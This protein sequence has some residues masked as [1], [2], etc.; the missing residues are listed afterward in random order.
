MLSRIFFTGLFISFLGT[1]PLGTLNVLAARM[2]VDD[3][4]GPAIW[5]SLGA[6]IVEMVY[7]RL[8]L[9][10]M[11]WIRRQKKWLRILEGLTVCV[12]LLLAIGSF[13]AAA[14]PHRGGSVVIGFIPPAPVPRF[15][16]GMALS[17]INPLQIPFWF[18]WSTVLF[19][20]KILLPRNDHYRV[21]IAGIGLGTFAGN[22]VFI[23]G[24]RLLVGALNMHQTLFNGGIGVV[25]VVTAVWQLWK[26]VAR[27]DAV[28]KL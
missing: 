21:Y 19:S 3:G 5:F 28:E 24:G 2:A 27:R 13:R 12:I 15:L 4:V 6:L 17:A 9:V 7:V 10:A 22:A 18:G 26:M 23:F 14:Y 11:D 25:F 16:T 20:K 1:L 8:S